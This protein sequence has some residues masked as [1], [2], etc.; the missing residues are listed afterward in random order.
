MYGL[1]HTGVASL[2]LLA[3]GGASTAVGAAMKWF[4]RR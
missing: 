3:L 2:A 4:T 1:A